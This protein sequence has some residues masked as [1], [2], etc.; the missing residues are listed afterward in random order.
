MHG[1]ACVPCLTLWFNTVQGSLFQLREVK[2]VGSRGAR[3]LLELAEQATICYIVQDE[4]FSG[5]EN[6]HEAPKL[7]LES[8]GVFQTSRAASD[9][10]MQVMTAIQKVYPWDSYSQPGASHSCITQPG[11]LMSHLPRVFCHGRELEW[12]SWLLKGLNG[13]CLSPGPALSRCYSL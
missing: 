10:D 13:A 1:K 2:V 3:P 12:V 8:S 6:W 4:A 5:A 11:I 9:G 7:S